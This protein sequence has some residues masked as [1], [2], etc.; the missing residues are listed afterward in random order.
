MTA[1]IRQKHM[2]SFHL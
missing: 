2:K 1:D